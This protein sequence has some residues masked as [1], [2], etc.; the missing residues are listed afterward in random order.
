MAKAAA[1]HTCGALTLL[2]R[3]WVAEYRFDQKRRWRFDFA[4]PLNLVAIEVEGG[5]WTGGRHT[6]AKGFLGDVEKYNRAAFLGWR[7][8]R[9]TPQTLGQLILEV[10][11]WQQSQESTST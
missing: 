1:S 6:R 4:D 9:C 11:Q 7:V 5:V 10:R 8:F 2:G 3:G